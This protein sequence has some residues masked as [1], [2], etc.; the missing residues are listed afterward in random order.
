M[1][2][3][4]RW[5]VTTISGGLLGA[6]VFDPVG[7][8]FVELAREAGLYDDILK[9]LEG[10]LTHFGAFV[11]QAWFLMVTALSVGLAIGMWLDIYLRYQERLSHLMRYKSRTDPLSA[12]NA[13][14]RRTL[15]RELRRINRGE[16]N[17]HVQVS[18]AVD[19]AFAEAIASCFQGAGWKIRIDRRPRPNGGTWQGSRIQGFNGELVHLVQSS[20]SQVGIDTRQSWTK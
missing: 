2:H 5:L 20:L 3:P 6:V 17:V 1:R 18:N 11:T 16:S 14:K 9:K 7:Q 10:I 15:T 13:W 4:T 8:I 19:L 12:F